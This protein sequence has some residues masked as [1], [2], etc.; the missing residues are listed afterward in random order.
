MPASN[1]EI[2]AIFDEIADLLDIQGENPFRIRAYRNAARLLRGLKAEAAVLLAEGKDLTELPGIGEDLAG[3]IREAV[4]TGGVEILKRLSRQLPASL[5]ELLRLP[6]LGPKRAKLLHDKLGIDSLAELRR[7]AE[8]GRL[9]TVKGLGA[10]TEE[11]LLVAL[12]R[13]REAG[14]RI[15][16]QEAA[17][18][19]QDLLGHLRKVRGVKKVAVA[20]SFRRGRETIGDI[21]LLATADDGAAAIQGFVAHP[22]VA[23]VSAQGSTRATVVLRAGVQADLRVVA[24]ESYGAALHYFTGSKA[25]NIAIRR[26]AQQ[27]GLKINEYGVFRGERRVA[28]DSEESV[29]AAVGLPYIPPEL[30]EDQGE[31]EAAERKALPE[32]LAPDDLRG[33]LHVHTDASD[34]HNT[35]AEMAAAARAKGLEY[36]AI[37]E[38][39]RRLTV[40]HGLDAR[41]LGRLCAAI[42]RL[43]ERR[44]GCTVLKGIEADILEDG[45]LDLPDSVLGQ[46]DLVIGAVH[47]HFDLPA[48]RQTARL[49]RAMDRPHFSILA[50]PT[51]R[52]FGHREAMSF[53][54]DRIVRAA[55]E[56]GCF[57]ELNSQPDRLDL[58][59]V[60]CRAA[61]AAGVLLSIG[62]DAHGTDQFDFLGF[63][64]TQ[65]RRGWLEKNDILNS[66][67]LRNLRPLLARTM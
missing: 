19:A 16:L 58:P 3:K 54:V 4:D 49:L 28:G 24:P 65:A 37:T 8:A 11:R 9:R 32:L 34:G 23:Q 22:A 52:L 50:H 55:K 42:D 56:R 12:K 57:L 30:R 35:L 10:K 31:I 44:G 47:S 6:G 43:N 27:R 63:G 45:G 29:F 46:L 64:V 51:G 26:R 41:R 5:V 59:D 13:L 2:A 14:R 18:Y 39:T 67:P 7:A 62:S 15:T 33:D 60:Y 20:G 17:G 36:I 53:D 1:Q 21:D 61:K 66:R 38:H 25:H 40:A 48:G